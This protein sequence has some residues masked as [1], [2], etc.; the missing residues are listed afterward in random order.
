MTEVQLKRALNQFPLAASCSLILFCL[1]LFIVPRYDILPSIGSYNETRLLEILLLLTVT[2]LFICNSSFRDNWLSIYKT[3]P[4][5]SKFLLYSVVTIGVISSA[6][7]PFARFALLEVSFLILLSATTICIAVCR[8][9]LAVFFDKAIGITLLF[10]GWTYLIGFF[11]FYLTCLTDDIPFSFRDV[12]SDFSNIRFFSQFQ[13][14][15]LSLVVMPLIFFPKQS[16]LLKTLFLSTAICWWFF[17]FTSGTR[18]T[19]LGCLVAI[20]F[21]IFIF[22]KQARSWFYWQVIAIAGGAA[23]YYIFFFLIPAITS[24]QVQSV[25]DTTIGRMLGQT[26]DRVYLWK[27]AGE[28]IQASPW[29]GVGPMQYATS[30]PIDIISSHPHNSLLQIAAEWGI[31][32]ALTVTFLFMWGLSHWIK[33]SR[34]QTIHSQ[35]DKNLHAALLCAL[36]TA[37]VHSLFSGIIVMPISQ[38]MMT[39]VIGWMIGISLPVIHAKDHRQ[40]HSLHQHIILGVAFA[41]LSAGVLW[42]ISRDLPYLEKLQTDYIRS[43]PHLKQIHPRFWH[44]GNLHGYPIEKLDSVR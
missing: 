6:Y 23:S 18:G 5:R 40:K 29:F 12:L 2:S 11:A 30:G 44:Q 31:P 35:Q 19:L 8:M 38:V 7:S 26:S 4:T 28:M 16:F 1:Y 37:A 9:Q 41:I 24:I 10:L 21:T 43:H 25:L 42:P 13:S 34:Q 20:P 14:W 17:L 33:V 32:V 15:T 3:F 22:G 36:V 39:L 27:T